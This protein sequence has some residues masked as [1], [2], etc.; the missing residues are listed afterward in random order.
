MITLTFHR[1]HG[2]GAGVDA[3]PHRR[4]G[5]KARGVAMATAALGLALLPAPALARGGSYPRVEPW[6]GDPI[7]QLPPAVRSFVTSTCHGGTAKRSFASRQDADHIVL[8]YERLH[9]A[10]RPVQCGAN[11]CLHQ[12]YALEHG[13]WHLLRSS[14]EHSHD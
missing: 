10:D 6:T 3:A 11:G 8:H 2:S 14:Y 9:C 13:G 1:A 7:A 4:G 5:R 12:E